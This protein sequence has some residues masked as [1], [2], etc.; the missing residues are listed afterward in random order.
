MKGAMPSGRRRRISLTR[1]R[2]VASPNCVNQKIAARDAGNPCL[3]RTFCFILNEKI[4]E[5]VSSLVCR[6]SSRKYPGRTRSIYKFR[7]TRL[8]GTR[9]SA[10]GLARHWGCLAG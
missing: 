3:Q 5:T 9:L 8:Y 6:N 10:S 1:Q 2:L 4:R 7:I